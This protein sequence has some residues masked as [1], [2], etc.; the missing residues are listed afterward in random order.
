MRGLG[1]RLRLVNRIGRR[2]RCGHPMDDGG[3]GDRRGVAGPR[4]GNLVVMVA[5]VVGRHGTRR[6]ER[7]GGEAGD[8]LGG[9]RASAGRDQAAGAEAPAAEAAAVAPSEALAP[10]LAPAPAVA[11]PAP[12]T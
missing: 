10:A 5:F 12:A 7:G 4:L 6:D 8:R 3:N 1:G 11:P 9:Q 2:R